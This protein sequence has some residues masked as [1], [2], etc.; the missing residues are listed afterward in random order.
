MEIIVIVGQ[1]PAANL[2]VEYDP[3]LAGVDPDDIVY[4]A[5]PGDLQAVEEAIRIRESQG[6]GNVTLVTAGPERFEATLRRYLA[7]GADAAIHV[8]DARLEKAST[9]DIALAFARVIRGTGYD[10]ILGGSEWTDEFGSI[11]YLAPYLAELLNLP[12][13]PGV[14]RIEV[15]ADGHEVIVEQKMERGDRRILRCPLPCLLAVEQG[16]NEPRYA[17]LPDVISSLTRE[18]RVWD[19]AA[20]GLEKEELAQSDSLVQAIRYSPP[21]ARV[22]KGLVIDTK[23]PAAERM[24]LVRSGGLSSRDN[25]QLLTGEAG[26]LAEELVSILTSRG[27]IRRKA[28]KEGG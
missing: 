16:I 22:K 25:R 11:V 21:R 26:K 20:L 10:L 6:E 3:Y 24:K 12:N 4:T 5:S 1:A 23:L 2:P 14:T 7:L 17:T 27:I 18:I 13:V 19:L 9:C 15:P 8:C 28:S